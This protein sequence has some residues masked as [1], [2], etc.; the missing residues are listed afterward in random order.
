LSKLE[1]SQVELDS[2]VILSEGAL[3]KPSLPQLPIL[4]KKPRRKVPIPTLENG[5]KSGPRKKSRKVSCFTFGDCLESIQANSTEEEPRPASGDRCN[6]AP[7]KKTRK[8]R[9]QKSNPDINLE[10]VICSSTVSGIRD[11]SNL[12]K[13]QGEDCRPTIWSGAAT[14]A[15][16]VGPVEKRRRTRRRKGADDFSPAADGREDTEQQMVE[17]PPPDV[18]DGGRKSVIYQGCIHILEN[19]PPPHTGTFGTVEK[20]SSFR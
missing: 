15:G 8:V 11:G 3:S 20:R 2:D 9:V 14:A 13:K 7:R 6:S 4:G 19:T 12:T 10:E 16:D 1:V 5:E 18:E 17:D